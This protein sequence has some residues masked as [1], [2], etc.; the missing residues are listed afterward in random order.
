MTEQ[1]SLKSTNNTT[2][3]EIGTKKEEEKKTKEDTE[4]KLLQ[5]Y[6]ELG[7]KLCGTLK[8][9]NTKIL[10]SFS[11]I[12][13]ILPEEIPQIQMLK[14][15]LQIF[16]NLNPSKQF[17]YVSCNTVLTKTFFQILTS[18][19]ITN[20]ENTLKKQI[21]Q[22]LGEVGVRDERQMGEFQK[23]ILEILKTNNI[24]T[25]TTSD[26]YQ[27]II[28]L[29][30]QYFFSTTYKSSL[31]DKIASKLVEHKLLNI[32]ISDNKFEIVQ[33]IIYNSL[34]RYFPGVIDLSKA[35]DGLTTL[36]K[37]AKLENEITEEII[38]DILHA[39]RTESFGKTVYFIIDRRFGHGFYDDISSFFENTNKGKKLQ[40][41]YHEI[42]LPKCEKALEEY[43]NREDADNLVFSVESAIC[44]VGA[45]EYSRTLLSLFDSLGLII[46]FFQ[47][48]I[49]QEVFKNPSPGSLFRSN[50]VITKVLHHYVKLVGDEY[51]KRNISPI[52]QDIIN[53][54]L[55]FEID[56]YGIAENE[57]IESNLSAFRTY[58]H[59]VFETISNTIDDIPEEIKVIAFYYAEI[60][61]SKYPNA[62]LA[63]VGGFVFLRWICPNLVA[64]VKNG[65][66]TGTVESNVRRSL[67]LLSSAVQAL[68]N[69]IKFGEMRA[70]MAPINEDIELLLDTRKQ[71]LEDISNIKGVDVQ[72]LFQP[73]SRSFKTKHS[74]E[75]KNIY[76]HEHFRP[77]V[78]EQ[79]DAST[80]A[81]NLLT[82]IREY[83]N[84]VPSQTGLP[85][86]INVYNKLEE[87]SS[88]VNNLTK[89]ITQ[90]DFITKKI[91]K[92]QENT[93]SNTP[94]NKKR[95]FF[96]K[97]TKKK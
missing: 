89:L 67:M 11:N 20:V 94:K 9:N 61:A 96:G 2:T 21:K 95:K 87:M 42:I 8:E 14:K 45:N 88:V 39:T 15:Q 13:N 70:Y 29:I 91:S 74:A 54:Q 37:M 50:D 79:I 36:I 44:K 23:G 4:L 85:F 66:C 31:T 27:S 84:F 40:P 26:I 24:V 17:D 83:S 47:I 48:S 25:D 35:K 82:D 38:D 34:D 16:G 19:G 58:F 32:S 71:F 73:Y 30:D 51:L 72:S 28:A 62:V 65:I 49:I 43:M 64:P 6:S 5:S 22:L 53:E 92:D 75:V 80:F 60:T 18:Y 69:G 68:S 46:P 56:P 93:Q 78:E 7:D 57:D 33:S 77:T 86:Y 63:T 1:N 12:G 3:L 90:I 81:V 59:L 76:V 52:L 41:L 97:R 55:S 10:D